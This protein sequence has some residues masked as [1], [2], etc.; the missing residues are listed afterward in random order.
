MF[1]D[2]L[3]PQF[4][5][6]DIDRFAGRVVPAVPNGFVVKIA[7]CFLDSVAAA[8]ERIARAGVAPDVFDQQIETNGFSFC[9]S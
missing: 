1:F 6:L 7:E 5:S 2:C 9:G 3:L 4:G 8:I